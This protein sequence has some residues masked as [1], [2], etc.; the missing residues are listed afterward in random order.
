MDLILPA[1]VDSISN[2]VPVFGDDMADEENLDVVLDGDQFGIVGPRLPRKLLA[3]GLNL[4]LCWRESK[5]RLILQGTGFVA[6][7]V[8]N[9]VLL[10]LHASLFAA[11]AAVR[12]DG[13]V[14]RSVELRSIMIFR[15]HLHASTMALV[16]CDD[17]EPPKPD[18]ET[19]VLVTNLF[20]VRYCW[21]PTNLA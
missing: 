2:D 12:Q 16:I 17:N 4:H 21:R 13:A 9:A 6:L 19:S 10:R 8:D 3:V 20:S 15:D 5:L 7:F 14:F 1:F 11:L 18:I